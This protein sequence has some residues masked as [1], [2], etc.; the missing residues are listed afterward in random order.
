MK[1]RIL[2]SKIVL[3]LIIILAIVFIGIIINAGK[4]DTS[5]AVIESTIGELNQIGTQLE[6][7]LENVL[8]E[9]VQDLL[10][11]AQFV[12]DNEITQDNVEEYFDGQSLVNKFDDVYYVNLDGNSISP[13]GEKRNLSGNEAFINA[14]GNDFYI[15]EPYVSVEKDEIVFSISVPVVK[16]DEVVAILLSEASMDDFFQILKNNSL[17]TSDIFIIDHELKLVFSTSENHIGMS[18][19]PESDASEIGIENIENAVSDFKLGQSGGFYYNYYGVDKVMS[20]NPIKMTD[21]V[22]AINVEVDELNDVL[23]DA[24]NQ[25]SNIGSLVYW[26]IILL[27]L[28]ITLVQFNSD[29]ALKKLAYYDSLTKLP[30]MA[31]FKIDIKNVLE[32]NAHLKYS[33]IIFDIDNFKAINEMFGYDVGDRVLQSAKTLEEKLNEPSLITARIGDDKFAMFA[34]STFINDIDKL[35]AMILKHYDD[36]VSEIS[37]YDEKINIGRYS[38]GQGETNVEDIISKASLAHSRAKAV[39]G[40]MVCD[41]DSLFKQKLLKEAEITSKM[42]AALENKEFKVFLQPKFGTREDKLVGAEALVRWVKADGTMIYPNDFIPLFERNGFIVEIDKYILENVCKMLKRWREE[43]IGQ[44]VVSVNC[45]RLNLQNPFF[46]D[47]V[48]AIADKY[49]VPHECIEIELT[50]STT[51]AS[52]LTIEQLFTDLHKNNFKIS[53]DD[54]GAGYSSLGMLKNL[55]VDTLKMDRSFFVGGKNARRDDMLIDSIVK[56]SHNLG[57]YVVAE[58]IETPEQ[59]ALLKTMNCDA[60]QGYVYAKPMPINEFEQKYNGIIPQALHTK[61]DET[62]IQNINDARFANSFVPCGILIAKIDEHFTMA[63]AND[64]YFEIVGYTKEELRDV[65]ANRGIETLHEDDRDNIAKHIRDQIEENERGMFDV[66]CRMVNKEQSYIVVQMRGKTAENERGEKRLYLSITDITSL[67]KAGSDLQQE[68]EFNA[69]IAF[70]TNNVFF[71]YDVES[72]TIH[73]SKNFADKFNIPNII[74]D[75]ENSDV[76]KEMFP[77]YIERISSVKAGEI[78]PKKSE[79]EFCLTLPNGDLIWYLY[80]YKTIY[81]EKEKNTRVIGEMQE[82]SGHRLAMDML[83]IKS[84]ADPVTS[85]YNKQ[86]TER[87]IR[88]YLRI[89]NTNNETGAF[90]VIN[91]DNFEQINSTFGQDFGNECLCEVG[92][93]LRSAFRSSDII[94]RLEDDEFFVF[95]GN[96]KTVEFVERKAIELCNALNITHE[97]DD[98]SLQITA[99]IGISF[100]PEHGD[101]FEN[102]FA[103]AKSALSMIEKDSEYRYFVYKN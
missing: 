80:N 54:F 101:S 48:V 45:S 52:E 55:Q 2:T 8:N 75:F 19:I 40:E 92:K 30:N 38:I 43:N 74:K 73:F 28:Y 50:E 68:K 72:G 22:L 103:K 84:E 6:I 37:D 95:L 90:F 67:T 65:F 35:A 39:K 81:D 94:G 20:Y 31:K 69:H 15:S 4:N 41:Y 76:G 97:K 86:A 93:T 29:K 1:S 58:G 83:R 3:T 66:T 24:M 47:G 62:L 34:Q 96:Y 100:Y 59:V 91:L 56:M 88:N 26:V 33:I 82:I 9:N 46:V 57:M 98:N 89:A 78:L 11:F 77:Q 18:I 63:E 71:D 10:I 87:Y 102:V 7:S 23:I 51:I 44:L 42:K 99:S 79:G 16:E 25:F 64:G 27:V 49:G 13:T 21:W 53:I 12:A 61:D 70:L 5:S 60:I 32:Y 36:T 14:I 85:V 17:G